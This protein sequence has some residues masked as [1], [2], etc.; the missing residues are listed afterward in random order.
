MS[1]ETSPHIVVREN[2]F[3]RAENIPSLKN[4]TG[5][6]MD[7]RPVMAMCRCGQSSNKPFCDG[8]HKKTGF[9]GSTAD[10]SED[11]K[12]YSY[13]GADIEVHYSKH[14]CSH[15]AECGRLADAVFNTAQ[16]P[17]IQPDNGTVEQIKAAVKACPSGALRY[18]EKGGEPQ[19]IPTGTTGISIQ[20]NGPYWVQN[21]PIEGRDTGPV[22]TKDKY[23][24]CR[25]GLSRN[26]PY[27]DGTHRD[28]NWSD[29]S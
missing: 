19:H 14:L 7:L 22:G 26:K 10:N 1:D 25:C 5:K 8:S 28:A 12:V 6:E 16:K 11:Q 13:A 9:D 29:E 21:I 23:V 3:I 27:C 18:S 15:A 4:A 17:W 2:G 20:K 24:L